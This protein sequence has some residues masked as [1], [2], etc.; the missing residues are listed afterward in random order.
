[1]KLIVFGLNHTTAPIH[2]REKFNFLDK[3]F[4]K[5]REYLFEKIPENLSLVVIS[6]CNRVE[7][8]LSVLANVNE[9][10]L[11]KEFIQF[12][13]GFNPSYY[14]K[15]TYKF[16]QLEAVKHL[17][18]VA[19]GLDSMVLGETEIFGQVKDAYHLFQNKNLTD[20]MLNKLFQSSFRTGKKIRSQ[21]AI[22]KLPVSVPGVAVKLALKLF[23]NIKNKII[24]VLGAGEM[25]EITCRRLYER[26]VSSI[27]VASRTHDHALQLAK[28]FDGKAF[29]LDRLNE[30]LLLADIVISQTAAPQYIIHY[31]QMKNIMNERNNRPLFIID[32]A[33]PRDIEDKCKKISDLHLYNIDD[34]K[35]LADRNQD[36]RK[37]EIIKCEKLIKN[38]VMAFKNILDKNI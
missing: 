29:Q 22:G 8:Y 24:L 33:V 18:K 30:L 37:N 25:S 27:I 1:M 9:G 35:G 12:I 13:Y 38:E 7:F 19:G 15:Y 14:S 11:I 26:G 10:K 2:I 32:I 17:Y 4:Q 16:T 20:R 5:A 6:T 3:H 31:Q 34:L 28:K 36:I 21:T 23:K